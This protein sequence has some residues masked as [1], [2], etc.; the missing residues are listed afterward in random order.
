M[1]E[2]GRWGRLPGRGSQELEL[3]GWATPAKVE[4]KQEGHAG[5]EI[6]L[7]SADHPAGFRRERE[8]PS[9]RSC[10]G[11]SVTSH[12]NP[13]SGVRNWRTACH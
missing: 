9:V 13:G 1:G 5:R 7:W 12:H 11:R 2:L 10:A 8:S 4:R 6:P 3:E